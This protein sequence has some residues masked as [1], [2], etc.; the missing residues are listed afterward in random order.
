M[1][2]QLAENLRAPFQK[3]ETEYNFKRIENKKQFNFCV[4]ILDDIQES[5]DH[6]ENNDT[7]SVHSSLKSVSD[8]LIKI[9]KLIRIVDKSEA[10]WLT[11]EEYQNDS[12]ASDSDNSQKIRQAEE[13]AL[14]KQKTKSSVCPKPSFSFH[15]SVLSQQFLNASFNHEY[16]P[17]LNIPFRKDNVRPTQTNTFIQTPR[18]P[19]IIDTCM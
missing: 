18:T 13:S 4:D 7:E 5:I 12:A 8:K 19:K 17:Q 1:Q 9:N 3:G 6:V 15:Q 10:R 14:R 2:S 16:T 11:I